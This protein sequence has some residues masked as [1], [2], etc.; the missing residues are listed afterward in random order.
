MAQPEKRNMGDEGARK[1]RKEDI[2]GQKNDKSGKNPPVNPP[3]KSG[4][5]PPNRK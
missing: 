4:K 5:N 3:V 2:R 1:G